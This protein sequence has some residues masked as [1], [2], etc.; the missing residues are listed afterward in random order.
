MSLLAK[1]RVAAGLTQ[2]R[3]AEMAGT[4]Q[5]QI[6]RLEK[7]DRQLTK[8]WAERLAPHL[9]VAPVS[10]MF[11]E[12]DQPAA[13]QVMRTGARLVRVRHGG[14]VEAGA[15]READE[16]VE[17]R[18]YEMP[19][20]EDDQFPSAR[21]SEWDVAGDSMNALEPDPIRPGARII[22]LDYDD[23]AGRVPLQDGMVVV[24]ERTTSGGHLREWSVKQIELHDKE[25][26]FHPRS[27]NP[28]HKSFRIPRNLEADDGT[29][30]RV[31]GIVTQIINRRTITP[32]SR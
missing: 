20:P 8:A 1:H 25:F 2:A 16:F 24:V 6:N 31:L 3:L 10:L 29:E 23:I 18:Y 7:G 17:D 26:E 12:D 22:A 28:K 27:T 15:F 30:V 19:V 9:G 4:S 13:R 5:P 14:T 21:M 32:A 11:D